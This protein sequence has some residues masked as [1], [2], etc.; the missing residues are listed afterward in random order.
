MATINRQ[1]GSEITDSAGGQSASAA[2]IKFR[3]TSHIKINID[4][5]SLLCFEVFY[6]SH[7]FHSPTF[8][9]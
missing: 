3:T 8:Q 9:P 7:I 4:G 5:R 2:R 6:F 1:Y